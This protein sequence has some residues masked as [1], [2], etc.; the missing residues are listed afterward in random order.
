MSIANGDSESSLSVVV[1][2]VALS[3]SSFHSFGGV[4]LWRIDDPGNQAAGWDWG[5]QAGVGGCVV[6]VVVVAVGGVSSS[7]VLHVKSSDAAAATGWD[8]VSAGCI[9]EAHVMLDVRR[10]LARCV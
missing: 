4:F 9:I 2:F 6:G 7:W 8:Y 3:A 1:E 5:G 10:D